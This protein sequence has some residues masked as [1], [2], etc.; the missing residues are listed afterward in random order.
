[1][2]HIAVIGAVNLDIGA[3]ARTELRLRDSNIGAVH[4]G[5]GGV[6]RN[7]AHDLCLMGEEVSLI[8]LFGNDDF[9]RAIRSHAET[10]GM[11]LSQSLVL[12]DARTSSYIYLSEPSGDMFA[13]VN[14]MDI[15]E[16]LTPDF[17]A[18]RMELINACELAVVDC[19]IP[20][21]SI[22]YLA[23]NCRIPLLA[24]P[25]SV[26][27][28]SRLKEALPYLT[29]LKPNRYE[30]E[31][32]SGI[33]IENEE[34]VRTA[35]KALLAAGLRR[36]CISLSEQ[37]IYLLDESG[38]EVREHL[39]SGFTVRNTTGCGDS[40]TAALAFAMAE[41]LTL[42]EA[43]K[44]AIRAAALTAASEETIS[45]ELNRNVILNS[46]DCKSQIFYNDRE[47]S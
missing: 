32:L 44:A 3:A 39:P 5:F 18:E 42:Q 4:T 25:V 9:A 24:D 27:K 14:D 33:A 30:A 17:L 37:G 6:G 2:A 16:R 28:A 40:M 23:K 41:G 11:D 22:L 38:E 7:I 8:T 19:N 46:G 12:D 36:V 43:A 47:R 1:M 10:I 45:P 29:L 34:D 26:A 20:A 21:E 35:A 31:L 15:Y 13:A